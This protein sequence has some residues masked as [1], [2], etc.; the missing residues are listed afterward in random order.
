MIKS[1]RSEPEVLAAVDLGSN[2]FHMIVAQLSGGQLTVID[3]LRE[4][5]RLA[6][7]LSNGNHLDPESQQR[8][9]ECLARFGERIRDIQADKARV[10]GTNTL[11]QLEQPSSFVQNAEKLLGHPIEIIS[12]IEEARLIYSGASRSLP[13]VDGQQLVVDIG[14]GST[15][16]IRGI[17]TNPETMESL[18]LGCVGI[19]S[20]YF[21]AGKLT[22]NQFDRARL[23]TRRQ[24]AP[25]TAQFRNPIPARVAGASGTI[26]AAH[27][28][29]SALNS[30]VKGITIEGLEQLIDRMVEAGHTRR[31][32]FKGLSKQREPVFPGGIVIL[33]ELMQAL[34][35]D[36]MEIADGS[37]RE[38]ILYEMV[39]RR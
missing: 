22:A 27:N 6:A 30:P 16:I 18:I 2:S 8:A 23:A 31:L 7:G 3:R 39:A 26:R 24:L 1:Q 37:L 34:N 20:E 35:I 17:G 36:R 9:L 38:G 19:S 21:D 29:L 13:D 15:E 11:R 12:G 5:V 28:V 32:K 14:G 25:V 4:M 33:L 10:V